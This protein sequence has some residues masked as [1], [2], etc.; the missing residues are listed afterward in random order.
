[1]SRPSAPRAAHPLAPAVL[2]EQVQGEPLLEDGRDRC[3]CRIDQS[4]LDLRTGCCAPRVDDAGGRVA[5]LA[6]EGQVATGLAI[7]DRAHRHELVDPRRALVHQDPHRLGVAEPGPGGEGVGQV[8]I[9]RVLVPAEHR[10]HAALGPTGG[11]LGELGLGQDADPEPSAPRPAAP[12]GPAHRSGQAHRGRKAGD[13]APEDQDVEDTR[14][15]RGPAHAPARGSR[16][17]MRRTGPTV[18]AMSRRSGRVPERSA[19]GSRSSAPTRAA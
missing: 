16:L 3:A 7:E 17:S 11:R 6:G 14:W 8:Q 9:G 13:A 1:M 4:A 15:R 19:A 10:G 5:A 18:A 12:T 2:D